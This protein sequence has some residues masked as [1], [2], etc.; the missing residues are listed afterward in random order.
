MPF[1]LYMLGVMYGYQA[2]L[3]N[4]VDPKCYIDEN[5]RIWVYFTDKGV[6][7]DEFEDARRAF[8]RDMTAAARRRRTLRGSATDFAD[9]PLYEDYIEEIEALGALPLKKSRWLNAASFAVQRDDIDGIAQLDFVR[10]ISPVASFRAPQENEAAAEDTAIYGITY[11]QLHMF[12]IDRVHEMGIFGSDVVVGILDTGLRRK[13]IALRDILLLAEYDF[14]GG[15]QVFVDNIAVTEKYGTYS[16]M[17]YHKTNTGYHL[18]LCGDTLKYSDPVRDVLYTYSSDGIDWNLPLTNITDYY[19][20]WARE[21]D[22]CG[23]DTMFLLFRNRNGI[24]CI[25]YTDT[26]IAQPSITTGPLR[27]EPSV[28]M[29]GDTLYAIFHNRDSLFLSKGTIGGFAPEIPI[30][31]KTS[32]VKAP[33]TISS[34]SELGVFYHTF[35]ED[36]MY[37]MKSGLNPI[38]FV[39]TFKTLGKDAQAIAVADTI[40][41][42]WK[43]TSNE[44]LFRVAFAR[45]DD[46]GDSFGPPVSLSGDVNA[47]GK[48]TL[49]KDNEQLK[50]SWESDGKVY[51]VYSINNG[52]TF[53][54]VDSLAAPFTYL[55][56]LGN[57]DDGIIH[58][59]CTRGDSVTDGYSTTDPDYWHPRHGTE[60]L[61]LIGGDFAG[62][63]RGVAPGAQFLVAKTEN[64]ET[65][66]PYEFPV[67]EDTY[68]AGLEWCESMGV[69]IVSSSLGYSNWYSWPIDYDGRTSP[70]SIAAYEATKRGVVVVTAAGNINPQFLPRIDAPGDAI[71]VITVGGIDTLYNR[72]ENSGYGPTYDG[73]IKPEIVCLSDAPIVV[74]PDSTDYLLYSIG[75]SGATAMAAGICAL[76][77]EA[78]PNWNVDSVRNALFSTASH[79][80]APTDSMGYG[81]P[82]A[83]AAIHYSPIL[84][85]TTAG[86]TWLTPYPNPFILSEHN[87]IY[88]PFK[89]DRKSSVAIRIYSMSGKLIMED[90]REGLLP[91]GSYTDTNPNG[92]TAAFM[93]DGRDSNGNE[94][95]S[96]IYY[97]V[98]DTRGA[99][100]DVMKIAVVR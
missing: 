27:R 3:E 59:Y 47:L 100:N 18:F 87:N 39:E 29:L 73:R 20:N 10:K 84:V 25:A 98:L 56:T 11:K 69:D 58:F 67:E 14:L 46:F 92:T 95:G 89:L 16:D 38:D 94:V 42:I 72:W 63:Y 37:F 68:I 33:K 5:V 1:I 45:S 28:I 75:T 53:T 55:P 61:G 43:D 70:A 36:T 41:L 76:L 80:N 82:D 96:G 40:F 15:D 65:Q 32:N 77:L 35:P 19:N 30:S 49:A 7:T 64:P 21:L 6:S 50:V 79:A 44:P 4:K 31:S 22:V 90:E 17:V 13:P 71:D 51:F 57:S 2:P 81:W 62:R 88:A 24:K 99:G 52:L 74:D 60:M 34:G 23:R 26:I 8:E 48:I 91:P 93:W 54:S 85:D 9:L 97:C 86:S 83:F 78:H 12:G 66:P